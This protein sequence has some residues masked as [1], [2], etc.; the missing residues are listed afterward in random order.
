MEGRACAGDFNQLLDMLVTVSSICSCSLRTW[1]CMPW[2][3]LACFMAN[4]FSRIIRLT[5]AGAGAFKDSVKGMLFLIFSAST[6]IDRA[7]RKFTE[8]AVAAKEAPVQ[9]QVASQ[10][11]AHSAFWRLE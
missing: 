5:D 7:A 2:Y 8:G 11:A 6:G 10:R 4:K 9:G 1:S 3:L